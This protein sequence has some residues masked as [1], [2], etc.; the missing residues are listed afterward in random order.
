M[1]NLFKVFILIAASVLLFSIYYNSKR[2]HRAHQK[3]KIEKKSKIYEDERTYVKNYLRI[4]LDEL[5]TE[6]LA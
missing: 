2:M 3:R 6:K 4:L 1:E 5:K